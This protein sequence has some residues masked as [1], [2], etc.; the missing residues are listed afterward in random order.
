MRK[1]LIAG[2]WKAYKTPAE[3]VEFVKSLVQARPAHAD[4]NVLI[5]PPF[6]SLYPVSR[7][8]SGTGVKLGAQN[9]G[10]AGEGAYTGEVSAGMLKAS[11]VEYVICG[12]SERRN[13]FGETNDIVNQKLKQVLSAGMI[14]VLCVGEQ[15]AEREA[16]NTFRVVETQLTQSL[17]G[18]K[19]PAEGLVIAYE[20]VWAIGTGRNATPAQAEEVHLFIRQCLRKLYSG[21]AGQVSIL[22]GGS[23]KPDNID[24]LMAEE[25]IDGVLVGGASL[26]LESFLR[27][28]DYKS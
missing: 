19:E 15:L 12:H 8:L 10:F 18:I 24:G 2:N 9:V 14:P 28:I 22:Y 13:I 16:G 6:T 25:N 26:V 27:I 17:A 7:V 21:A 3:S 11:G 5:C 1:T 23:V 4:R 20:P